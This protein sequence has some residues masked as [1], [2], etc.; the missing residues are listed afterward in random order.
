M[1]TFAK[2]KIISP[3]F[4]DRQLP[5]K[6]LPRQNTDMWIGSFPNIPYLRV[7]WST[8]SRFQVLRHAYKYPEI[9]IGGVLVGNI[10][11]SSGLGEQDFPLDFI[12]INYVI[13][14]EQVDKKVG[15]FSFTD[16]SWAEMNST[17]D[18]MIREGSLSDDSRIIGW[19]HTHPG[20][21]VF[22]SGQDLFIQN[23]FFSK[24]YYFALVI[25]TKK[26][27]GAF[28]VDSEKMGGPFQSEV[29]SWDRRFLSSQDM[30][31]TRRQ[32]HFEIPL[33]KNIQI[34]A[35]EIGTSPVQNT[36]SIDVLLLD[37]AKQ[38]GVFFNSDAKDPLT[39]SIISTL[40]SATFSGVC[41]LIGLV[42]FALVFLI[43]CC[44]LIVIS[45][46]FFIKQYYRTSEQGN[47]NTEN[48][49]G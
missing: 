16:T 48:S 6:K 3:T 22:L 44:I 18:H 10:Y 42:P 15:S 31:V 20:H 17:L 38:N 40:L 47:R 1:T 29:F 49:N 25:E 11:R 30:P 36:G 37:D 4:Y 46:W 7:C 32:A 34:S 21:G 2:T 35:S 9:E 24:E 12:L 8:M 19:Y 5:I 26:H 13:P 23:N 14:A 28:F 43:L 27:E 39:F 33:A 45:L 41:L